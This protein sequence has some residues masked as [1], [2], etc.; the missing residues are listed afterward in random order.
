M[1]F[2]DLDKNEILNNSY[3]EENFYIYTLGSPLEVTTIKSLHKNIV[4]S[5]SLS[6]NVLE[7]KLM[8]KYS[9][10]NKIYFSKDF[11]ESNTDEFFA[12]CYIDSQNGCLYVG[13][14]NDFGSMTGV[15]AFSGYLS[16]NNLV[17]EDRPILC[18]ERMRTT[19]MNRIRVLSLGI[20]GDKLYGLFYI[21][22]VKGIKLSERDKV[23]KGISPIT[24][25]SGVC[26]NYCSFTI[27]DWFD[28]AKVKEK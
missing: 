27:K 19:I 23:N 6:D 24:Y 8:V 4:M 17:E 14:T 12:S 3:L 13:S 22:S 21:P 16:A 28:M 1:K 18:T 20:K 25:K 26:K 9:P 15:L 11:L 5:K 10:T 2:V 7:D